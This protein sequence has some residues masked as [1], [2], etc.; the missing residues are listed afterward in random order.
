MNIQA[1]N[2]TQTPNICF[3]EIF[4]TLKEGE[5][6]VVLVLIRQT[7]G[8]HKPI[9]KISIG[10][11]SKKSGLEKKSVCR[12]LNT[13]IEKGIVQKKKFGEIG[14]ERCYYSLVVENAIEEEIDDDDMCDEEKELISKNLYQCPKD[15]TPQCPKDTAPSVLGTHTKETIQKKEQQQE[16]TAVASSEFLDKKQ[17]KP[18]I[19]DNLKNIEI[20]EV[21]KIEITRKYNEL[22]VLNAIA[23][24]THPNTKLTKGLSPAIKWACIEQPKIIEE[25]KEHNKTAIDNASFNRT[26]FRQIKIL[27]HKNGY[28]LHLYGLRE[29]NEYVET[30]N[31]KIYF[32]DTSFLEQVGSHLRKNSIECKNIFDMISACKQDLIKQNE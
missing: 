18:H 29:C 26:Y 28:L 30:E 4:K 6:R 2:Y 21:D 32:K 9:D 8:W 10:Q 24:A 23:W 25:K 13:L 7:F 1:P 22:I 5:L 11:I 19:F 3:D 15:T 14:K 20:P 16:N 31:S 12:S 27:S 17:K